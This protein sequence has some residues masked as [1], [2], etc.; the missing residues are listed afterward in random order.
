MPLQSKRL[1]ECSLFKSG[2][3]LSIH[4]W[5]EKQKQ[6]KNQNYRQMGI[7]SKIRSYKDFSLY[8]TYSSNLSVS[9]FLS[10]SDKDYVGS[11]T[12]FGQHVCMLSY[13][14]VSY[15][16]TPWTVSRQGPLSM[17]FLGKNTGV[18][19]YFLLQGIFWTQGLNSVS[20]ALAG[21]FFATE[22]LGKSLDG[23]HNLTNSS[24]LNSETY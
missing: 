22:P 7:T 4:F 18:D 10:I 14:V 5:G 13:S 15:S 8:F 3:D 2:I 1:S 20:P 12:G 24:K 19:C 16:A 9:V 6:T 21:R 11:I 17:E 23:M